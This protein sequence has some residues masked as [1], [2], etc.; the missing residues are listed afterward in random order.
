MANWQTP[1]ASWDLL[2]VHYR[3]TAG[4]IQPCEGVRILTGRAYANGSRMQTNKF[5]ALAGQPHSPMMLAVF[6][7]GAVLMG[8]IGFNVHQ[9]NVICKLGPCATTSAS[10]FRF[11]AQQQRRLLA[12]EIPIPEYDVYANIQ[13]EWVTSSR[14]ALWCRNQ[15][16]VHP[17]TQLPR[18]NRSDEGRSIYG[19]AHAL[20]LK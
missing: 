13:S 15:F 16:D 17:C 1:L 2:A 5:Q 8:S 18:L 10:L 9:R 7:L 3:S 12:N 4:W 11:P 14:F 19:F 6:V 20:C